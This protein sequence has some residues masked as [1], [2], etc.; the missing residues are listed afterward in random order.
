MT[1][2]KCP[3]CAEEIQKEAIKCKHCMSELPPEKPPE[4]PEWAKN[5]SAWAE[6]MT[7]KAE[8]ERKPLKELNKEAIGQFRKTF[9]HSW[10]YIAGLTVILL[11]IGAFDWHIGE[12]LGDCILLIAFLTIAIGLFLPYRLKLIW[13][14]AGVYGIVISSILINFV[15]AQKKLNREKRDAAVS[16]QVEADN[17][18]A[19]EKGKEVQQEQNEEEA[20][21]KQKQKADDYAKEHIND[22][23]PGDTC[24]IVGLA[25]AADSKESYKA[26]DSARSVGDKDGLAEMIAEGKLTIVPPDTKVLV[27]EHD[28]SWSDLSGAERIRILAKDLPHIALWVAKANLKPIERGDVYKSGI[29]DD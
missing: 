16:Q 21:A 22:I 11:A 9:K 6:N 4:P 26:M 25:P 7:A 12:P 1:L 27:L 18:A 5:M 28:F 17:R 14:C 20:A 24:I 13:I 8:Q 19:E 2:K 15:P 3:F 23:Y 29:H 10:M